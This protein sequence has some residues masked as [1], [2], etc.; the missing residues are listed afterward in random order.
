MKN[1]LI[2]TTKKLSSIDY[3][4]FDGNLLTGQNQNSALL[5]AEKIVEFF[6]NSK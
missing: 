3:K 4:E 5:I 1:L 2:I 6:E